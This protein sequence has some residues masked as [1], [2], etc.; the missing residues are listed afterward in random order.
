MSNQKGFSKIAIII[1]VLIAVTLF[2][3]VRMGYKTETIP[4]NISENKTSS[5][6]KSSE[7]D[8]T[9]DWKIYVHKKTDD[10]SFLKKFSIKYPPYAKINTGVEDRG[11]YPYIT[12]SFQEDGHN[13]LM[14][15]PSIAVGDPG[16]DGEIVDNKVIIGSNAWEETIWKDSDGAIVFY[17]LSSDEIPINFDLTQTDKENKCLSMY[18]KIIAT[19]KI[20]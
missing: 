12:I 19:I 11:N 18:K 7:K 1:I 16:F 14:I 8:A 13:C 4:S 3:Y 15:S 10:Y 2:I 5:N 20:I 6:F 17:G 9:V